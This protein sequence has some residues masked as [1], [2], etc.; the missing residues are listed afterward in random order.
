MGLDPTSKLVL[1]FLVGKRDTQHT[2]QFIADLSQRKRVEERHLKQQEALAEVHELK[3]RVEAENVYL[4]QEIDSSGGFREFMGRSDVVKQMLSQV[5]LVSR[6]D[7]TVLIL[8][9]TGTGK[10]LVAR[11]IHAQSERS[12]R[13]LVKVNCSALPASLIESELFGHERGAFTGALTKRSGRFELA[14]GGTLFLD[15][16][17]E[18]PLEL[19]V[20]L[21]RVLQE[22]EFERLGSNK[23]RH[24]DV[25]VIAA[26]NRDLEEAMAAG[27]F[28]PDLYYRLKVFPIEVPPL[29]ARRED[30]P[31]LVWHFIQNRQHT[32]RRT[33]ESV[34]AEV[35]EA[36]KAYSWPGNVR[37]LENIIE[38]SLIISSETTL[39]PPTSFYKEAAPGGPPEAQ[40]MQTAGSLQPE[41]S[42][43][44]TLERFERNH[45]L[46]VLEK[47]GWSIKGKGGAAELLGLKPT[48][49]NSRM[50]RLGI[51]RP[52]KPLD[53]SV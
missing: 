33:I 3:E 30:I 19:Q 11:A 15:E 53:R 34:S 24:V 10:E 40:A 6:T 9:E 23:T 27:E 37:E 4:R 5:E 13:M 26:T 2:D 7:S 21:L 52:T 28:R 43:E 1:S 42:I 44:L 46:Q 32:L 18:L 48:T 16:I 31:L 29:R 35:M 8:G 14:D 25:R 50:K 41:S 38:H 49:L 20:K 17:G 39:T 51:K 36:F 12:G 45:I 47:V 22:G